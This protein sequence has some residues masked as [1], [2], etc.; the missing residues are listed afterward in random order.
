MNVEGWLLSV[1]N[2]FKTAIILFH[3]FQ[4]SR[5][6]T[7]ETT[8]IGDCICLQIFFA[9]FNSNIVTRYFAFVHVR[10]KLQQK[11]KNDFFL[12]IRDV[13][14]SRYLSRTWFS[15]KRLDSIWLSNIIWKKKK[16]MVGL[17]KIQRNQKKKKK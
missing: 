16:Y 17:N 7:V 15:E 12:F 6:W 8:R 2:L 14:Y 9:I 5:Q 10:I 13:N 1:C 3:K 11:K 4:N